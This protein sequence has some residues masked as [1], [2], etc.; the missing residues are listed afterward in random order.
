MKKILIALFFLT[1]MTPWQVFSCEGCKMAAAKGISEPQTIM[2][3]FAFS[4]SVLF[5][6]AVVFILLGV[7][8][9]AM[10]NACLQADAAHHTSP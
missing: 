4:W 7:F 5:M 1:I 6:L 9:W 2:A 3:G 8:A 10:R